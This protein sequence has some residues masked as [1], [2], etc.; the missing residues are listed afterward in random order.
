V[1][2]LIDRVDDFQ[3]RH[4]LFGFPFAVAKKFGDDRAG[5]LAALIAYYGFFSVFP[6]MLVF[7]TIVGFVLQGDP[8][9][10]Q[11]VFDGLK[12]S[13][14]IVGA[15]VKVGSISASGVSLLVGLLILLWAGLG[16]TEAAQNAFNDVWYVPM[17]DR[18][19]F[20]LR[21]VRDLMLLLLLGGMVLASTA[22]STMAGFFPQIGWLT[23]LGSLVINLGLF[24]VAFRILTTRS[25]GW[26]DVFP[27]AIS[28]AA[29]FTLLQI[30]GIWFVQRQITQAGAVYGSFALVIGIMGWF[31][32]AAQLTLY[33]AELNT[34]LMYRLWPRGLAVPTCTAD[35]QMEIMQAEVANRFRGRR[36]DVSVRQVADRPVGPDGDPDPSDPDPTDTTPSAVN[37]DPAQTD[38]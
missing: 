38:A 2:Q 36:L 7:T 31:Y 11:K 10:Q 5:N 23:T 4:A 9:R 28:A 25:L 6:L 15:Y 18:P 3:R 12:S 22:V 13:L 27:G 20:W 14:P 1:N 21:K 8:E 16:A 24:L 29:L 19:N 32:L 37:A 17:R 26:R 30:F 34:V 33:A 35:R